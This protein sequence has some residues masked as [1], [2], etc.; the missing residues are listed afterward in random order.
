MTTDENASAPGATCNVQGITY[1]AVSAN[2]TEGCGRCAGAN[3]RRV[4]E[5]LPLGCSAYDTVWVPIALGYTTLATTTD[6]ARAEFEQLAYQHYLDRKAAGKLD[7]TAE[8]DGTP[9][10]LFWKQEDGSYGVLMFNAAWQGF[11]WGRG[12]V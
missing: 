12:L 10:A 3:N 7:P 4:C 11:K 5:A 9:E 6:L 2:P 1:L 8:G